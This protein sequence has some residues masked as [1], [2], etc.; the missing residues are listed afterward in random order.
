[1]TDY[2]DVHI[3]QVEDY[4]ESFRMDQMQFTRPDNVVKAFMSEKSGPDAILDIRLKR[5]EVIHMR[6]ELAEAIVNE[7]GFRTKDDFLDL[8][9]TSEHAIWKT[10][11]KQRVARGLKLIGKSSLKEWEC[12]A[13]LTRRKFIYS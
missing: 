13:F 3:L 2:G 5:R 1:M 8:T 4:D 9:F 7:E 11:L 12:Y 6:D 10:A